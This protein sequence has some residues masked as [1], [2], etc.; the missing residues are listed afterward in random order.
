MGLELLGRFKIVEP[1]FFQKLR[2]KILQLFVNELVYKNWLKI[3]LLKSKIFQLKISYNI[4][5]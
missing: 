5:S 2:I 1:V 4:F 3:V